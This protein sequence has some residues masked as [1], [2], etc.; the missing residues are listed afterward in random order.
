MR[1]KVSIALM[2]AVLATGLTAC[3][4]SDDDNQQF[5]NAGFIQFYNGSSNSAVTTIRGTEQTRILGSSSYGD[6]TTLFQVDG[7]FTEIEFFRTDSDDEEI[8][9]ETREID[10]PTGQKT[11]VMLTGD[12]GNPTFNEYRFNREELEDH[13][14]LFAVSVTDDQSSYDLYMSDS[15]APFTAAN[16]LGTI[17]YESFEE[18][19]FWAPDSDS[20]DFDEGSYTIY[21]TEP[22]SQEVIFESNTVS[23]QFATEYVLVIRG[24]SGAIQSG[25][26]VDLILNSS[27]VG[28]LDDIDASSQYRLYNSLDNDAVSIALDGTDVVTPAVELAANTLSGFTEVEFGDYRLSANST[29]NAELTFNNRL[30]TLNQGESKAIVIYQD[31]NDALTSLSF[32]ESTQPQVFDKQ[33]VAANL[34]S[35]FTD[36]DLY[37]V[38]KD[39]TIESAQFLIASIDF[40]EAKTVTLPSDFYELVAVFD[41]NEDTQVLLD[42]T[43]LLGLNEEAN[44]IIMIE[45]S[46]DSPTGYKISLLF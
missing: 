27:T 18:Q 41:D 32:D 14:R 1:S 17:N 38:R 2:G 46:L 40:G 25:I 36:V 4:S 16:L 39:E 31:E 24:S 10:I 23:F 35:D 15:G 19:T 11:L 30:V 5:S 21:L 3:S 8:I 37:F 29:T 20:E 44:Y 7:G 45:E 13:F 33:V 28:N 34:V 22:G 26:E 9:L 42:R 6:A 43:E 12:F